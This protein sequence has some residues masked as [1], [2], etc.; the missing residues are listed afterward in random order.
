MPGRGQAIEVEAYSGSRLAERPRRFRLGG[1]HY[2]VR[3]IL[4]SSVSQDL[5]RR[6]C[7]RFTVETDLGETFT[8]IYFES[9]DRWELG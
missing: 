8:L 6:L 5:S 7:R 4:D 3:R 2:E 9:D 1:R